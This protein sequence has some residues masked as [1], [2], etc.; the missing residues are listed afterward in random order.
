ME[1]NNRVRRKVISLKK[2]E[3]FEV[4][5]VLECVDTG[6][7]GAFRKIESFEVREILECVDARQLGAFGKVKCL[8]VFEVL[9]SCIR[10]V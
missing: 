8:E 10:S 3:C 6:Q 9:E 2:F 7:P 5:E 1:F 4:P